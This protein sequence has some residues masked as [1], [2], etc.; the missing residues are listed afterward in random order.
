VEA[1]VTETTTS[2]AA[3]ELTRRFI[4]ALNARDGETLRSLTAEDAEFPSRTGKVLRGHA[5]LEAILLAAADTELVIARRGEET[6]E[7]EDGVFRVSVP[8]KEDTAGGSQRATAEF[9]I[10]DGKIAAFEVIPAQ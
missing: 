9:E 6:V 2:P 1:N 8:V 10:R 7:T 3:T 4:E 5:G